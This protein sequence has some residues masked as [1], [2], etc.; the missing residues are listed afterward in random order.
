M[1]N[2]IERFEQGLF[3]YHLHYEDC[4]L[5]LAQQEEEPSMIGME[6]I[7]CSTF[8]KIKLIYVFSFLYQEYT[9]QFPSKVSL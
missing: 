9:N 7:H 6:V 8:Y 5:N 2:S 3:E 4:N 1:M